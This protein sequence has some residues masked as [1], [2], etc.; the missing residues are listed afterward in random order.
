MAVE[1]LWHVTHT[2]GHGELH[3]LSGK[4]A[5]AR[6]RYARWLTTRP[7]AACWQAQPDRA[8]DRARADW[9]A[10]RH[11]LRQTEIKAWE[12]RTAMPALQGSERAIR[13]GRRGRHRLVTGAQYKLG[14]SE[15]EFEKRI[16]RPAR[17]VTRASW[18]IAH[19]DVQPDELEELLANG[20]VEE[21]DQQAG[22][23]W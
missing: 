5:S 19:R 8:R 1:T 20:R 17:T 16:G 18:W 9:L 3:D 15:A 12:A 6:A 22:G 11:I 10:R 7:C 4:G 23:A 13:W 14:L 2:C 21:T